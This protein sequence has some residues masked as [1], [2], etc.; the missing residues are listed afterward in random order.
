MEESKSKVYLHRTKD[1]MLGIVEK[2][3]NSKNDLSVLTDDEIVKLYTFAA[4]IQVMADEEYEDRTRNIGEGRCDLPDIYQ[5][6]MKLV[7]E[8]LPDYFVE[9][10]D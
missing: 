3:K 6:E 10:I 1:M 9:R 4:A 5:L 8:I 7:T 2:L